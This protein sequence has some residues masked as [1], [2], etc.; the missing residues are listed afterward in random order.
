MLLAWHESLEVS[1]QAPAQLSEQQVGMQDAA[2]RM[3]VP[4][5]VP[6]VTLSTLLVIHMVNLLQPASIGQ[7]K[8]LL[9]ETSKPYIHQ[10][11]KEHSCRDGAL[12]MSL[13]HDTFMSS[14][15]PQYSWM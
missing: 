10:V 11:D 8:T 2:V 14:I 12:C 3:S 6:G 5:H 7:A 9:K 4:R 15:A 1:V 13:P